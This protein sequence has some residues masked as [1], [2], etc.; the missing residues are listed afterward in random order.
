M[1][2]WVKDRAVGPGKP[3]ST[4]PLTPR[5]LTPQ[6]CSPTV[7]AGET[8]AA[9]LCQPSLQDGRTWALPQ[10]VCPWA[11]G[12]RGLTLQ[13]HLPRACWGTAQPRC[14]RGSLPE[15]EA[16]VVP[17]SLEAPTL[18]SRANSGITG[19]D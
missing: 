3:L 6:L 2:V 14:T 9:R 16:R 18:C 19:Q 7:Q 12:L 13:G 8:T 17:G 11:A 15:P 1:H 5:F 10:C 4:R